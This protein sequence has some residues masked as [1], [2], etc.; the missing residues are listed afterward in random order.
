MNQI[1]LL[2]LKEYEPGGKYFARKDF[3]PESTSDILLNICSIYKIIR[4]V[5]M[6]ISSTS[7]VSTHWKEAIRT[8]I[9][10]MDTIC[11]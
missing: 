3:P 8:Y 10:F 2:D 4:P 5:F 6:K 7:V 9:G 11:K 1:E